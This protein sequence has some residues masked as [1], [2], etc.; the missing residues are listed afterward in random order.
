[1]SELVLLSIRNAVATLTLNA[2]KK[3]NCLTEAMGEQFASHVEYLKSDAVLPTIRGL[4]ITGAGGAFSSGGDLQFLLDRSRSSFEENVQLMKRFYGM[5]LRMREV[6]VPITAL[7]PGAAVGAGLCLAVASDT[8]I[9]HEDARLGFPFMKLGLFPGMGSTF[10]LPKTCRREVVSDLLVFGKE[11]RGRQAKDFGIATHVYSTPQ[12]AQDLL[13]EYRM[14]GDEATT[15]ALQSIVS[16]LRSRDQAELSV[17]LQQEAEN[18]ARCFAS[19]QFRERLEQALI[20][21]NHLDKRRP[22]SSEG[23][24]APNMGAA[25]PAIQ[26]SA[27]S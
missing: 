2:P 26:P 19:N 9:I 10:F 16:S 15:F 17:A 14:H 3:L 27:V 7:V 25:N 4:V 18:Q 12:Q 22:A 13:E 11:L 5:F 1:M 6:P 8:R 21:V 20:R 23:A 24:A